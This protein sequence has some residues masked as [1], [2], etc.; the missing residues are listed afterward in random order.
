MSFHENTA[1][2]MAKYGFKLLQLEHRLHNHTR[3][4]DR[5]YALINALYNT[6]SAKQYLTL[7]DMRMRVHRATRTNSVL[8]SLCNNFESKIRTRN[9]R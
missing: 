9:K 2:I 4:I 5:H 8:K 6:T 7:A 3:S 1:Q